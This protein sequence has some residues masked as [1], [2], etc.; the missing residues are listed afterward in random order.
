M[1]EGVIRIYLSQGQF[2]CKIQVICQK[3]LLRTTH[4]TFWAKSRNVVGYLLLY[5]MESKSASL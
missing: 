4:I 3:D 5:K 2:W 1:P